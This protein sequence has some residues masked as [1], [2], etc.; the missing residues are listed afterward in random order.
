MK[1]NTLLLLASLA[2]LV[3][4]ARAAQSPTEPVVLPTYVVEAP[5]YLPAEQRINASLN[6]LRQ[7]AHEPVVISPDFPALKAQV[8]P[9]PGFVQMAADPKAARIAKS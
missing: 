4:S 5:R 9:N 3:T 7:H 1:T 6:E 2:V 8:K